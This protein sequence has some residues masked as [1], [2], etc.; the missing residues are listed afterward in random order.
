MATIQATAV[1][2]GAVL[3][4]GGA[5]WSVLEVAQQTPSARGASLL[6]KLRVRNLLTG[7]V[8]AVTLRGGDTVAEADCE[9]RPVQFLYRQG[10]EHVF[11]DL[12]TYEQLALP[13]ELV[14]DAA[15]YLTEGLELRLLL[16]NGRPVALELPLTVELEVT[17]TAPALKGATAAAQLK[18]ATLETGLTVQVPPY[19]VPGDRVRVDTREARFVERVKR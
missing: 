14:A 1:Q 7:Q 16:F 18:P 6:V 19:I 10:E 4:M 2:R 3:E 15:G 8:Q 12:G 17:E 9:R 13:D 11:M 5:P